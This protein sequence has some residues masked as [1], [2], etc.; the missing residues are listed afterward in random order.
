MAGFAKCPSC[1]HAL[2]SVHVEAVPVL[3]TLPAGSRV[4]VVACPNCRTALGTPTGPARTDARSR[5]HDASVAKTHQ[6]RGQSVGGTIRR[7]L[8]P[9]R[10]G[11][12]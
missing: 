1:N 4:L 11:R 3:G 6:P 5:F 7:L 12:G 10:H 2:T 8:D 9:A